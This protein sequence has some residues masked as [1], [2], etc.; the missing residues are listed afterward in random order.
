[1]T[2]RTDAAAIAR[3][4]RAL[5]DPDT[6]L[7]D[8]DV[9]PGYEQRTGTFTTPTLAELGDEYAAA[10]EDDIRDIMATLLH[11]GGHFTVLWAERARNPV[12][13]QT[14]D[15]LLRVRFNGCGCAHWLYLSEC[16]LDGDE[17]R[18]V[19]R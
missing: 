14:P 11:E 5:R 19:T 4:L 2:T 12:D 15:T 16:V 13:R 6:P 18:D 10:S 3:L 8:A 17:T 7:P 9:L 1:M